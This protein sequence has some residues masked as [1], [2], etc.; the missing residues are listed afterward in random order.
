MKMHSN[1]PTGYIVITPG[2]GPHD[3]ECSDIVNFIQHGLDSDETVTIHPGRPGNAEAVRQ[4]HQHQPDAD[5]C[6]LCSNHG[7]TTWPCATIRA[8]NTTEQ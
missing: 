1:P 5:Y 3:R 4:L 7:D 2:P 6:D 8:L